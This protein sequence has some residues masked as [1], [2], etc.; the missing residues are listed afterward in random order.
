[1]ERIIKVNSGNIDQE[2]ICCAISDKKGDCG[3][4][5][6]KQWLKARFHDGLVFKKADVRGKVFIEYLPAEKAWCPVEADGYMFIDCLWVS[7]QYKG[8]GLSRRLLEECIND[9]A[10]MNGIIIVSSPKKLP[11]LADR[12][13]L[14]HYGFELCDTAPPYYE[15]FNLKFKK[16]APDPKFKEVAKRLAVPRQ[17]GVVIRYSHQCPFCETYAGILEAAAEE[18]AIPFAREQYQTFQAAQNSPCVST[19]FSIF[20][21]GRFVTHEILTPEKFKK[22]IKDGR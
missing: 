16:D 12:K 19:T 8:K 15:L 18:E 13:F 4:A 11:F 10:G 14:L 22:L 20:R 7:G 21:D 9:S 3:V 17:E 2:H 5:S 1:V 6:K